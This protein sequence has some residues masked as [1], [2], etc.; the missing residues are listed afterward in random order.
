MRSAADKQQKSTRILQAAMHVFAR[1]G[2]K[3]AALE[4]V[5]REAGTAK[6]TLYL[7]FRDK[8]ELYFKTVL[9]VFDELEAHIAAGAAQEA[10]PLEKLR[11]VARGQLEFFTRH[12]DAVRLVAGLPGPSLT[13][14]RKRLFGALQERRQR[15]L[16][17]VTRIMEDAQR[18]G[19]VRGDIETRDLVLSY[20]GAVSQAGQEL[21]VS[22]A[23]RTGACCPA[24]TGALP[25]GG[26]ASRA[27]AIMKILFEGIAPAGFRGGD[28]T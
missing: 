6:G 22:A 9:Q 12:G 25:G 23:G 2:F 11:A 17:A 14:L 28:K 15:L 1:K 16:Q 13:G 3:A 10:G 8:Q 24:G 20:V 27:D 19:L 18:Q 5:A 4:E 7:Y 21:I 26:A